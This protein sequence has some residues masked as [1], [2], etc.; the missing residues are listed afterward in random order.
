MI[1]DQVVEVNP[2]YQNNDIAMGMVASQLLQTPGLTGI[3]IDINK[4]K[5]S[6]SIDP[7]Y[8]TQALWVRYQQDMMA[9]DAYVQRLHMMLAAQQ[10][11]LTRKE[12]AYELPDNDIRASVFAQV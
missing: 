6:A 3:T 5:L 9:F 12:K 8:Q 4:G 2:I 11:E 10:Y 1:Q 7:Q